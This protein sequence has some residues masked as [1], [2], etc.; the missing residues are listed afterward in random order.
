[1]SELKNMA[2]LLQDELQKRGISK[3]IYVLS[4]TKTQ[5]LNTEGADFKLMRT[6]FSGGASVTV[7]DDARKGSSSGNDCSEEGLRAVAQSAVDAAK[8]SP[9]DPAYDIA[10]DQGKHVFRQGVCEPDF[11]RFFERLKELQESI[12]KDYPSVHMMQMAADHTKTHSLYENSNGTQVESFHGCYDVSLE[13]SAGNGEK[14]SGVDFAFLRTD[15]LE[16]PLIEL[17]DLRRK[18][19]DIEKQID[20]K[21]LQGKFEG[22][23]LFT[24]GCLADMLSITLDNYSGSSVI[25]DGT[26]LWLDKVGE[27]VADESITI[28]FDPFDP[29]IVC[30][31][32]ITGDG[33]LSEPVT[34]IENGVLKT[35]MLSLYAANKTGRAVMKNSGSAM[36][37]KAGQTSLEEIVKAIPKGLLV[38]GFSGGQPGTNGDFSG[39]AKNSFLIEDGRVSH[40][41]TETMINGNLAEML[42]HVRAVSSE[43][44]AQGVFTL[45]YLAVDGI[46]ISGK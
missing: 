3:Y 14:N 8:S 44:D 15:S 16:R 40:A 32:R 2:A 12:A 33:F 25:L 34:I 23:V 19:S 43:T 21:P 26:S 37:M 29:S 5:E 41:V 30:G 22:T 9:Q 42:Q 17:S 35:H 46:V 36:I 4:E 45:P 28:T 18:F 20:P 39:V 27:Q 7:Y 1:M 6:V 24:P 13:F 10:P 31:E 11:D 38:G